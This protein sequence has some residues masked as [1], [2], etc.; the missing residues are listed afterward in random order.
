MAGS[1]EQLTSD[2]PN[3]TGP[4]V[5]AAAAPGDAAESGAPGT[6]LADLLATQCQKSKAAAA[7]LLRPGATGQPEV[8]AAY[9][10]PG[11]N[12]N[13][14]QWV[15]K[16]KQAFPKV[17]ATRR[18][19]LV[20]QDGPPVAATDPQN[21]LMLVP[22]QSREGVRAAAAFQIR[23]AS[24]GRLA[25]SRAYLEATTLLLDRHELSLTV[26]RHRE[27]T[28]RL[29][30]VLE[31]LDA[32]NGPTRFREAAMVLC[33]RLAAWLGC[34]RV[35]IG[36]LKGPRVQVKAISHTDGFGRRM[37]VVQSL[38]AVMEECLDQDLEIG[39]PVA[40]TALVVNRCA[41]THAERHGPAAILSVPVRQAG[42]ALAVVTLERPA[43]QAFHR[44]EEIEGIRL[45]CDLCAPRLIDL[46]RQDR[47]LGARLVAEARRQAGRLVGHEHTGVKLLAGSIFLIG[48]AL[49]T[50]T[51][52]YRISTAFA[53]KAQQRQ[54]VTAPFDTFSKT[55]LVAP[56][57]KVTGGQTVLGTLD[58]AELR[59]RLA[60]LMAEQLGY[61][62][63]MSAAMRDRNTAE[64][65]IAEAQ[66]QA[67]AARIRLIRS[68]IDQAQLVAPIDGWVVSQDR[69]Q[70][71]GA[72]VE[73]GE[74]LFEISGVNSL[75]AELYVPETAIADVAEGQTGLMAA[76]GHPDQRT[77]FV[78]E[79]I[80][81]IAE[82]I[83]HQNVF[84]VR[85]RILE[86]HEWM[87]PG[88]E[89]EAKIVV[90]RRTYL[91]MATHQLVDWLRFKLWI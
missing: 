10:L 88:M 37:Q 12:G 55:V 54:I 20:R 18:T 39:Y 62:K 22:I 35:S 67:V 75:R 27:T 29:R 26:D 23:R 85:A 64:A 41:V 50:M 65:H 21:Y 11:T 16:A 38:E 43:H 89:G 58:T 30:R 19:V 32:V 76:V 34:R 52:E 86:Q 83:G 1:Q 14:L 68:R 31:L 25:L 44:Q 17:L 80:N 4:Q 33:N 59:L 49:A 28:S 61:R 48:M 63:Q 79:R 70:K 56:G 91:W 7:V 46:A 60:A 77:G 42:E 40:E 9:P 2:H 81:P 87:R 84:R 3:P 13:G 8:L 72:P 74:I 57:D 5:N 6:F 15:A 45:L 71:I 66:D 36:F 51:G 24:R 73:T 90:G 82:V 47:W 53:L 78:V 69:T